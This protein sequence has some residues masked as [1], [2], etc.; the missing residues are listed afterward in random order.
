MSLGSGGR[1]IRRATRLDFI[2]GLGISI[3]QRHVA[4]AHL[5]KR[6]ATVTLAHHHVAPLPPMDSA[7][8]RRTALSGVV[9]AFLAEHSIGA[10]R[11]FV[12]LP[13]G[14]ALLSRLTLPA[15]ARND[16]RQVVEFEI[17]RLLP[18]A[19]EEVFFDFLVRDIGASGEKLDVLVVAAQRRVVAEHLTALE[20]AD[21]RARSVS[22]TPVALL[23]LVSFLSGGEASPVVALVDDGGTVELDVIVER[24][25]AASHL[26]R[27]E[28]VSSAAAMERLVVEETR[29]VAPGALAP[30]VYCWQAGRA[31]D[32]GL[33]AVSLPAELLASGPELLREAEK[34]LSAPEGFFVAPDPALAPAIGVALGAVREAEAGLNLLPA[35]ERR[36]VE[37]GPPLLTFFAAAVLVV[38]T[39]VWL[40]S[41]VIQDYR[42]SHRLHEELSALEPRIRAV[43][44]DEDQAKA[45]RD[46]LRVLTQGDHRRISAFLRE[47]A[48]VVPQDAYLSTFRM[49]NDR[50]ELEGF[51]KSASD[52]VPLLEKSKHFKNA[53]FTSPVTK[54]QNNQERFSLTT[55]IE[56]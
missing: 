36:A 16:L 46:K 13:R 42:I 33:A 45:L 53:Q 24:S 1:L 18:V 37:E 14:S 38:V 39:L 43:H 5:V 15:A 50:I 47:L 12:A 6:L 32:P 26:V 19:K 51:A 29:S 34:V 4:L 30:R 10:D 35:E 8:A 52:L 23:D 22:I 48:E 9:A 41:A 40:T 21:V 56:E 7:E 17:D 31:G 11:T 27:S 28:E 3:G 44:Q 25:L 54:V 49:R 20:Q 55:E 2:E